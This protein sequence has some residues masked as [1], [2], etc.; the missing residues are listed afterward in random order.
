M[1][2]KMNS[3]IIN[4]TQINSAKKPCCKV[5][6]DAGKPENIYSNHYVKDLNG[7]VTCPTLLN[8]ECRYCYKKGHTTSHCSILKKQ[9]EYEEN[10]RKQQVNQPKKAVPAPK[11]ANV[12]AYLEMN[13]DEESEPE[14]EN[15]PELV[16]S[17]PKDAFEK[18]KSVPKKISYASIAAKTEAEYQIEQLNKINE[19]KS[20]FIEKKFKIDFEKAKVS[21]IEPKEKKSWI[22]MCNESS[23]DE[24]EFEVEDNSAW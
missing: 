19:A 15:F 14:V 10:P 18:E 23:S 13:S 21:P 6:Q 7:N 9:K 17:E 2:S 11:K 20:L 5:C 24:E 16:K 12:F 4:K 1:N 8:Q 3:K 22:Q